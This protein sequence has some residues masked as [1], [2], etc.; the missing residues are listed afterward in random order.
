MR[1]KW[2]DGVTKGMDRLGELVY[3]SRLIG[4]EP[5][6]CV[7]GGGNTSTKQLEHDLRSRGRI[8]LRVKGSGSDLK[9]ARPQDFSPL[10]LE[11]VIPAFK[12][13][14]MT[15]EEM[16]EYLAS[17]LTQTGAPRPSIEALLHAFVPYAD[18]DHTH[19]DAI[20]SVTN[21]A[22]GRRLARRLFGGELIWVPYVKPGFLLA[23]LVGTQVRRFPNAKGAILENHGLITWGE[24]SKESYSRTIEMVTRAEEFFKSRARRH[25]ALGGPATRS[26]APAAREEF[27]LKM[28]PDI[29]RSLS[30]RRPVVLTFH[31]NAA[32]LE[33]V[34]SRRGAESSQAGPA[35]PDHMLRT[36]RVPLFIRPPGGD[37]RRLTA[38]LLTRQIEAAAQRHLRYYQKFRKAGMEMLDPYP[39][40]ILIP[41][42]GMITSGK[43][44]RE[45]GI[46]A[47][48]YEHS[49][50]VQRS[51]SLVSRY[52]SLPLAKAFEVEYWPLELYKLSLS[53]P[54]K[55]LA[56]HVAFVTGA[57]GAI[58][59][60][61]SERLR[62][63][64]AHVVVSDMDSKKVGAFVTELNRDGG[65]PEVLGIV[66]DVTSEKSVREA[67]RKIVLHFGGID[68][69]VSNAGVAHISPIDELE[70]KDWEKS[71]AV[72]AT[73]HFL[74]AR[75]ALRF[76]RKQEMGG[77]IIF[78]TTK[79]VLS[80]GKDFGAYSI[81]KSAEA[82]L[83]RMVAIE[84]GEFGIRANMVN[85][86]GVFEG[87]GL[88]NERVRRDRARS[89]GIRA[90]RLEE[91]YKNRN[92][93]KIRVTA[94]DVA[95]AVLFLASDQSA[96]TSGC[97]L[98]VDGGLKEAFPR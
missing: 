20:L 98:T 88:W 72:N 43:D 91:F 96:K 13:K 62:A 16:V 19:A 18:I 39:R 48:I 5:K 42:V 8:I 7:W 23:K 86:D 79:N 61:I 60:A 51:V 34:N 85:P 15:D 68:I 14:A 46:V 54:E 22:D 29:R 95:N 97:I 52:R 38:P 32:I 30:R 33:F 66:M 17:C 44:R 70:L 57:A 78:I 49:I 1:N 45:A 6:L 3:R 21:N 24:C 80:P 11:S 26:L 75:E 56:R 4:S 10:D 27:L 82:Q 94:Q 47:E 77:N 81:S 59:R 69:V 63:E 55:A 87:S 9:A 12:R 92:L 71:M 74:V 73:G 50:A 40:V 93:L 83:C 36:K 89:Y 31:A 90:G 65:R 35:T 2:S 37:P 53:P 41:G 64:G 76:M 67:L 58:G 28:L 84:N 25:K